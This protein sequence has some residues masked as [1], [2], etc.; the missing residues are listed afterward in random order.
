MIKRITIPVIV[1]VVFI[2][3]CGCSYSAPLKN[4][5]P[6]DISGEVLDKNGN[7]FVGNAEI[8]LTV[9]IETIDYDSWDVG[10]QQ[11]YKTFKIQAPNGIFSWKGEGSSVTIEG[12]KEGYHSTRVDVYY[13]GPISEEG[14]QII[15]EARLKGE[16][17]TY[18]LMDKIT[19][20]EVIKREG[21][22][23]YLIQKGVPSTLQYTGSAYIPGKKDKES[24]GKRC[25][26]S[27]S[28]RWYY[29]V[30]GD[31]PVDIIRGPN[32][33]N[34]R[35]Y[36]IKE[37]GGF[38]YFEGYPGLDGVNI[39]KKTVDRNME[40]M[41][42]APETGYIT[43]FTP[44]EHEANSRNELF[45]YFK[46]TD[47]KYGKMRFDGALFSYYINPDGSRNLEVGEVVDKGP[48]NPIEAEWL[49]MEL[50][51]D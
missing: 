38:I 25:G 7:L 45:C 32:E 20:T 22:L 12:V 4:L 1:L 31:V 35:T 49:D 50:G 36:K 28:K 30:D 41:P 18:D 9:E 15:E 47:G 37:P 2:Q 3:Y 48:R 26:W 5:H 39:N 27:F 29:P 17:L 33:K 16:G 40:L 23:I 19:R 51:A 13:D 6:I 10:V 44:S 8:L 42:E 43:T 21:I 11:E 34:R 24:G 14:K 46:T